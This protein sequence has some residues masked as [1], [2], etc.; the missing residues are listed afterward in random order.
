MSPS[1]L[2]DCQLAGA[3]Q[4]ICKMHRIR[5]HMITIQMCSCVPLANIGRISG[6]PQDQVYLLSLNTESNST[7]FSFHPD[8]SSTTKRI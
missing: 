7:G 2:F 8:H 3:Q 1:K 4:N 5:K 6:D